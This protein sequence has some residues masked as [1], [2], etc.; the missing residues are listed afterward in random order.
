MRRFVFTALVSLVVA[1]ATAGSSTAR[2]PVSAP[3]YDARYVVRPN[4]LPATNGLAMDGNGNLYIA[5]VLFNR[6]L[7]YHVDTG[8]LEPIAYP[9]DGKG[10]EL[11]FP[12]DIAVGP[13]GD[14]FV[15]TAL[16]KSVTRMDPNGENRA[17]VAANVTDGRTS[18]N[19]IA[20]QVDTCGNPTERLFVTDLTF[21]RTWQ[22]GVFEVVGGAAPRLPN[23]SAT[24][25]VA[26]P[27]VRG[28]AAP[29]GFGFDSNG[30][31]YVPELFGGRKDEFGGRIVAVDVD[32]RTPLRSLEGFGDFATALEVVPHCLDPAEPLVLVQTDSAASRVWQVDRVSGERQL[33][34]VGKPGLD[35][36]A[37]DRRNGT[38]YVSNFITGNISRVNRAAGKLHPIL[39]ERPLSVPTSLNPDGDL[40]TV[41]D[42]ASFG[43]L[44]PA[45][46]SVAQHSGLIVGSRVGP[47]PRDLIQFLTP[48]ALRVR[49]PGKAD[50]V[51]FTDSLVSTARVTKLD[52]ESPEGE[53][54][55]VATG[56][57]LPWHIRQ[58]P[59]NRLLVTDTVLG[60]VSS[61]DPS[62]TNGTASVVVAGL[63]SPGGL[64]VDALAGRMYVSES[65]AGRIVAAP[66]A[67]GI[68]TLVT[69]DC[70]GEALLTP[71]GV[72]LDGQG[73]LL[74]V[75][76]GAGRLLRIDLA[77]R[78]CAVVAT[79]LPTGLVGPVGFN[80]TSDVLARPGGEILVTGDADGS[81]IALTPK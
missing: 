6:V 25:G 31:A 69:D 17:I 39:R 73:S 26:T 49:G 14:L 19:G 4:P 63:E 54:T 41:G 60:T 37:I 79:E 52:L 74:V 56:F 65:G 48:S 68:P 29:E 62:T 34:A 22:G 67:G 27:V 20:F 42:V 51:Y 15:T 16:T 70:K 33:L 7:R 35:N 40:V 5:Q 43:T 58:A 12:D 18:P 61:V 80:Y 30:T 77:T 24:P 11:Q 72:A 76:A 81:I 75:E 36:L 45:D 9:G 53:R 59:G 10:L 13:D 47:D 44:N 2:P 64:A 46:G 71:E 3:G 32:L 23:G 8:V 50:V 38:I 78:A 1:A 55:V 57:V 66:V 21:N 28:L